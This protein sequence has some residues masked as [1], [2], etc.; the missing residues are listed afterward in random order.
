VLSAPCAGC[1]LVWW[2]S[3]GCLTVR[4]GC[5]CPAGSRPSS[6]D[7]KPIYWSLESLIGFL[8]QLTEVF[9]AGCHRSAGACG[10]SRAG[11]RGQSPPA[12]IRI[13]RHWL[14]KKGT[15]PGDAPVWPSGRLTAAPMWSRYRCGNRPGHPARGLKRYS[16]NITAIVTVGRM[17]GGSSGRAQAGAGG[18][19]PGDKS[20]NCL[21]GP[22]PGK[23][24]CSPRLFQYRFRGV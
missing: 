5:S 4:L 15:V 18:Q 1:S 11:D 10:R 7:L 13:Q 20:R 8:T 14:Q 19:P 17:N 9:A 22:W 24:P 6:A 23:S 16:S 21:A 2:W 3:A 12:L